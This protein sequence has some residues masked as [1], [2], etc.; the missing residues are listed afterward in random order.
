[1]EFLL[2]GDEWPTWAD[3]IAQHIQP[4]REDIVQGPSLQKNYT[5]GSLPEILASPFGFM[6][7]RA[8]LKNC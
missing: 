6:Y 7:N 2:D 5:H 4:I 8:Y 3:V 1:M